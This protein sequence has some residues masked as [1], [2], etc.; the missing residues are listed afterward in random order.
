MVDERIVSWRWIE[1]NSTTAKTRDEVLT[2]S[3]GSS[4]RLILAWWM[5][6]ELTQNCLAAISLAGMEQKNG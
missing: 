1:P 5:G 3:Q 2:L 4:Y 6:T